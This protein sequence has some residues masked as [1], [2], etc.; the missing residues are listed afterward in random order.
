MADTLTGRTRHRANWRG[1]LI[2]QVEYEVAF[3]H[4][5]NGSGYY[6]TGTTLRWR[7]A[8]AIDLINRATPCPVG[9]TTQGRDAD[10]RPQTN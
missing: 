4:D 5:L 2:L 6:D 7:D 8:R 3:C 10:Q 9:A 1:K